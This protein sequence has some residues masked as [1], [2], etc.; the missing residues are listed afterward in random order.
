MLDLGFATVPEIVQEL[1]RRLREQRLAKSLTQSELAKRAGISVGAVK[2]LESTGRTSM[3][4]YVRAV[5]ALGLADELANFM[6]VPAPMSIAALE[7]AS[8][9]PRQR[10]RHPSPRKHEKA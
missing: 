6:L 7:K 5:W 4:T 3:E 8:A 9:P 10:V 1:G 2:I